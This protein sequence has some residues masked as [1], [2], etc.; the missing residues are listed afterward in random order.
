MQESL[1]SDMVGVFMTRGRPLL[2]YLKLQAT[3]AMAQGSERNKKVF[4]VLAMPV[5]EGSC[6]L[7]PNSP[8]PEEHEAWYHVVRLGILAFK[9][10]GLVKVH[11]P[12]YALVT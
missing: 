12:Q 9:H 3:A 11:P 7:V 8:A 2:E 5:V 1:Q 6:A 4:I 10:R